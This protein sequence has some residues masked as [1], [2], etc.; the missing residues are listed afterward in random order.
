MKIG[1]LKVHTR[2]NYMQADYGCGPCGIT[3]RNSGLGG[4]PACSARSRG[5]PKGGD[6]LPKCPARSWLLSA[7]SAPEGAQWASLS[8]FSGHP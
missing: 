8:A 2:W 4:L 6:S 1:N 5:P 3:R 7:C